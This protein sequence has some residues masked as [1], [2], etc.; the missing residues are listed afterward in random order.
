VAAKGERVER[1]CRKALG[2]CGAGR[3]DKACALLAKQADQP[4]AR[5]LLGWLEPGAAGAEAPEPA[6]LKRLAALALEEAGAETA[7]ALLLSALEAAPDDPEALSDLG[8]VEQR[9]GRLAEAEGCLRRA[10]TLAPGHPDALFNLAGVLREAGRLEEAAAL[11]EGSLESAPDPAALNLLADVRLAQGR[12]SE[13]AGLLRRSLSLCPDQPEVRELLSKLAGSTSPAA[14]PDLPR[15]L[16]FFCK[17][18]LDSFLRPVMAHFASRGCE[19][20]LHHPEAESDAELGRLMAEAD[21]CWFEWCDELLVRAGRLPEARK[22]RVLCRLHSYEAFTAF[23]R[24]VDWRA[25]DDLVFVAPHIREVVE[26]QVS[27]LAER[28][29]L[30]V[31]PNAVDTARLAFTER[32]KGF[33][34][35]YLGYINFK[36]GPMLLIQ[37][38]RAMAR[39]DPRYTLHIG[40]A[41]QEPRYALYFRQ[42]IAELGL[43]RNVFFEGWI[44]DVDGWLADKHYL[45]CTSL[46]EGHPVGLLEGMAKGLKPLI[47]NFY[48]ASRLF[49]RELIWND[50]DELAGLLQGPYEPARYR[51][52]IE[53]NF[54]LAHQTERLEALLRGEAVS[55]P[56]VAFPARPA[57]ERP[58]VNGAA[59]RSGEPASGV[60]F[61]HPLPGQLRVTTDRKCF[62]ADYCRGKRV[63]H[64]GCV[65]SGM[66]RERL[67]QGSFL[68]AM[69]LESAARVWGVDNNAEG[70]NYLQ[71][72]GMRDLFCHD[73]EE[74]G[75][76]RL[77][78]AP[79]IIVA[80]EILEHMDNPGAFLEAAKG[81]GCEVLVSVPNAYSYR[82]I[83]EISK[84][85]ELVHEDHNCY[86]SYTTLRALV[87][88]HGYEVAE[89]VAY[90][91]PLPDE[92]G[93]RH[94][95]LMATNPYFADG[96]IFLLRPAGAGQS[97]AAGLRPDLQ[98]Q[99]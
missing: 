25:V 64:M 28:C 10:L 29:R 62:V 94:R 75:S 67:T 48:G 14:A 52:F 51:A 46:L 1:V 55:A 41:F 21:A 86:F 90:Y 32:P 9:R 97:A 73:A 69:L 70:I 6:A 3:R 36:K 33:R 80:S 2:H 56:Q 72:L 8:V 58:P 30:H 17:R 77:D 7:A 71:G 13:A 43:G 4:L 18:G 40:G 45:I 19:V 82:A 76:L 34:V 26:S 35:A 66:T 60:R 39:L 44:E 88:K 65:D 53:E 87:A 57:P 92:I 23:P 49:P 27:G 74:L 99:P 91:W 59:E 95:E 22:V 24:Q 79:D 37:A 38:A 96:L 68:H 31:V 15:R 85:W 78:E 84:G 81:F 11:L 20:R 54:S 93:R 47:H 50:L 63:L 61:H 5:A 42:M 16:A 89:A 98:V 12:E 83:C